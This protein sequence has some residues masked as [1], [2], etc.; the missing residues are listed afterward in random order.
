[1][2]ILLSDAEQ[3]EERKERKDTMREK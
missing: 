3:I 1:M 2:K